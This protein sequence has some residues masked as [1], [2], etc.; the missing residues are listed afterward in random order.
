MMILCCYVSPWKCSNSIEVL[1]QVRNGRKLYMCHMP[2]QTHQASSH[3]NFRHGRSYYII[4][5]D[6]G[7]NKVLKNQCTIT[8]ELT[9]HLWEWLWIMKSL[10]PTHQFSDGLCNWF[11]FSLHFSVFLLLQLSLFFL[12]SVAALHCLLLPLFLQILR[13]YNSCQLINPG[14]SE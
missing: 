1:G 4:H 2:D 6:V 9:I 12:F 8:N 14:N 11:Y 7:E 5:T 3:P 13:L 10:M